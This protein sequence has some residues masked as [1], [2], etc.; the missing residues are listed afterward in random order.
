MFPAHGL[1]AGEFLEDSDTQSEYIDHGT[2][3][4]Q[5]SG[6]TMES[7]FLSSL[8]SSFPGSSLELS[9]TMA[10]K[11]LLSL[12]KNYLFLSIFVGS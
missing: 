9:K 7:M 3:Y 8:T 10:L 1:L 11:L 12:K 2:R 4:M 6:W 5:F